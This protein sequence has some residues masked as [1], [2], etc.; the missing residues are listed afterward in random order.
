[1]FP[2]FFNANFERLRR[3]TYDNEKIAVSYAAFLVRLERNDSDKS[4]STVAESGANVTKL[5]K[6]CQQV[7][8]K[9][10]VKFNNLEL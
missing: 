9:L 8:R 7:E 4:E 10:I 3:Q 5:Q 6:S 1:M 2:T